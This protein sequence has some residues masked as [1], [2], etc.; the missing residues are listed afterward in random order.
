MYGKGL[1]KYECVPMYVLPK[2]PVDLE[3]GQKASDTQTHTM[4]PGIL[5]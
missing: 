3:P 1:P 2:V 5:K 4:P